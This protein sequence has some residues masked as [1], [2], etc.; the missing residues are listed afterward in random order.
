VLAGNTEIMHPTHHN[1]HYSDP[2]DGDEDEDEEE[3]EEEEEDAQ[4]PPQ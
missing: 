3:E 2:S 4:C 1:L